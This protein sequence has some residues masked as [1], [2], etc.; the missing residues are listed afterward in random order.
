MVLY[1]LPRLRLA[2]LHCQFPY[3]VQYPVLSSL[4]CFFP[5]V[6]EPALALCRVAAVLGS[7]I[8][9]AAAGARAVG[10]RVGDGASVDEE[11]SAAAAAARSRGGSHDAPCSS[12]VLPPLVGPRVLLGRATRDSSSGSSGDGGGVS[13]QSSVAVTVH[14]PLEQYGSAAPPPVHGG[15]ASSGRRAVPPLAADVL[16]FWTATAGFVTP[17]IEEGGVELAPY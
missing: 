10:V 9:P 3:E 1:S 11:E 15:S 4:P 7:G 5:C 13:A 17:L 12:P 2:A 8:E 16:V 6:H 14:L